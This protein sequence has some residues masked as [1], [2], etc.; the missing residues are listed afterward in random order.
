VKLPVQ[1]ERQVQRAILAMAGL[2]FPDVLIAHVPNGAHL[3]GD[4]RARCMQMGALKGDGLKIG[5]PDLIAIWNRGVA[6]LEV[7][8]PGGKLSPQ[9]LIMHVRLNE[10][11]YTPAVVTS[12]KEAFDFLGERGAPTNVKDWRAE[13]YPLS[14]ANLGVGE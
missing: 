6:F 13:P 10:L 4:D 5:F 11:G 14:R 2:A 7:K 3:S 9:Q 1:T 12:Q 8:R